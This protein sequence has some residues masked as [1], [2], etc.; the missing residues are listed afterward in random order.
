MPDVVCMNLQKAQN[1]IQDAGVFFSR[2]EDASG[3]GRRQIN[4]SNWIVVG[5]HPAPGE[6]IGEGDAVLSVVKLDEP[7]PC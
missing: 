5:Q 2:S 7:N 1:R 4:D 6:V 3:E